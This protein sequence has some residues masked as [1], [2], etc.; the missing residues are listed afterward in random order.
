MKFK[1]L[2]LAF[3]LV[4]LSQAAVQAADRFDF[5]EYHVAK[6]YKG[7][8]KL[9]D[10]KG[11]EKG[12]ADLSTRITE[13]MKE[14]V[15][16]AG[17]YSVMEAGCGSGCTSVVVANNRT[18]EVYDF[19]RGGE[20]NQALTLQFKPDSNLMLVRWATDPSWQTCVF[21]SLAFDDGKWVAKD[22]LAGQGDEVCD[23]DVVQGARKARG[24]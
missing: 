4:A 16:F 12:F 2:G 21:E 15:T 5:N 20:N 14:G 11:R 13:A 6:V 9:P 24:F 8:L 7:K 19:P 18:G 17:E 1:S 22:A 3:A 23:G 10:F